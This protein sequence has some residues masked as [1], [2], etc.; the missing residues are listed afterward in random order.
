MAIKANERTTEEAGAVGPRVEPLDS[1]TV[2][3][4]S[5][6]VGGS[7]GGTEGSGAGGDDTGPS[8]SPP[9]DLAKGKGAVTE[10]EETTEAPFVYQEEDVLFRSAVTSSSHRPIT[11]HDVAEYFSD[12]ALVRLLEENPAIGIVVLEANEERARVI[13]TS[14]AVERA[15]RERK[16]PL[17]DMEAEE[18]AGAEAVVPRVTAVEEAGAVT[19]PDFSAKAYVPPT[20]HLF[21]PLGFQAYTPRRTK[22]DAELLLKD[23][24]THISNT[25]TEARARQRDIRDF[26]GVSSSLELY[27]SLPSSVKKLVDEAKFGEFIRTISPVRNDHAI[28][29]ALAER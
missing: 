25:W 21:V 27:E 17:R 16:E 6:V 20:P 8:G 7:S 29:V 9:K 13:A 1:S 10:E 12:E 11:K 3:G 5:P 19:R 15:E 24:M 2:A 28:L 14:E 23:P 22:Y 18:R 26:G 4:G